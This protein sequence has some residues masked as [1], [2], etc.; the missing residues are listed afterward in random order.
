MHSAKMMQIQL[1]YEEKKSKP[2]F[3]KQMNHKKMILMNRSY[4]EFNAF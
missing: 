2:S 3:S 1:K 4:I